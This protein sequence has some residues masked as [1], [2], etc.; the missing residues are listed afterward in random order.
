MG[1]T[2]AVA[3]VG[4]LAVHEVGGAE[5]GGVGSLGVAG[6]DR[7]PEELHVAVGSVVDGNAVCS[8][9]FGGGG[10]RRVQCL[11]KGNIVH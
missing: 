7:A 10:R 9:W 2:N 3:A 8:G 11:Q 4:V 5:V 1:H 6:I